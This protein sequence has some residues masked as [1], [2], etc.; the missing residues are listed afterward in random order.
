MKRLLLA[1]LLFGF[2]SAASAETPLR[3][4][5]RG[6]MQAIYA[7]HQ[8]RPLIVAFWSIDC[9]HCPAELKRLAAARARGAIF[10]LVLVSTD[11][12]QESD[13]LLARAAQLGLGAAEQWVFADAIPERLRHDIDRR[14]FGELPRSYL[15]SRE[16]RIEAVSGVISEERL[17][18]WL[19]AAAIARPT[20]SE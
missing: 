15:R 11:G 17:A 13:A 8:G 16:G 3:S 6:S 2:G 5:V 9:L 18:R 12:I 14:W 4:F 19:D 1:C 7:E 10:D 20:L